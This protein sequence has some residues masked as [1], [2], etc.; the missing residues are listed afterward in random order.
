MTVAL[1]GDQGKPRPA[2]VVEADRFEEL[3]SVRS[4]RSPARS[5]T[6]R[7]FVWRSTRPSKSGLVKRSQVMVNKPQTPPR[8]RLGAVVGHLKDPTMVTGS[9]LLA[10]FLGLA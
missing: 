10:V 2:L 4:L 3:G 6:P 7:F 1:H 9:R 5:S 8:S